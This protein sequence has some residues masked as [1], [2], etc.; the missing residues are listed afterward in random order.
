MKKLIF[1][2][3]YF[4]VS[5]SLVA[6]LNCSALSVGG[7]DS[8]TDVKPELE[9]LATSVD[10]SKDEIRDIVKS[11]VTKIDQ[12][13]QIVRTEINNVQNNVKNVQN[14]TWLIIG[15]FIVMGIKDIVIW[16]MEQKEDAEERKRK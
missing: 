1:A 14:S 9:K 3:I 16:K 8:T 13:I 6:M 10:K 12:K 15:I 11:A 4:F 2:G 5:I 7:T